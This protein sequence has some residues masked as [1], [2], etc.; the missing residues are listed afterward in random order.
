MTV[1]GTKLALVE[2]TKNLATK[3]ED[4]KAATKEL[5]ARV[6]DRD[7]IVARLEKWGTLFMV[8]G[9]IICVIGGWFAL[10]GNPKL[11]YGGIM[12]CLIGVLLI[13]FAWWLW[14]IVVGVCAAT[15]VGFGILIWHWTRAWKAG[16]SVARAINEGVKQGVIEF[17]DRALVKAV[18]DPIQGKLGKRLVDS[19]KGAKI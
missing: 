18:L 11:L 12:L 2:S 16:Q 8:L 13:G 5:A 1:E 7:S 4:V 10:Q 6:K 14:W 19:V 3:A 15:V 9:A 17:K